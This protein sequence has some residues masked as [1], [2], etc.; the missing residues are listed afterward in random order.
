MQLPVNILK[1]KHVTNVRVRPCFH[2]YT[3]NGAV[4]HT[5]LYSF[6][7]MGCPGTL[8]S[9]VSNVSLLFTSSVNPPS[10]KRCAYVTAAERPLSE[11]I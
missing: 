5:E 7:R 4:A 2:V 8:K 10:D 3:I 11:M 6:G 1:G 9:N